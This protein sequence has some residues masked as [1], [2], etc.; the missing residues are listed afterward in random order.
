MGRS[1]AK[2]PF[3]DA[4]LMEKIE[5]ARRGGDRKPIKTW[6]RRSTITPDFIGMTL[7]VYNGRKFVSVYVTENMV[8][9]RLGEFVPTR[10]FRKHGAATAVSLDKT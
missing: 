8:G 7:S 1:I 6:S 9:H 5:K 3:V 2:G 4:K 10:L